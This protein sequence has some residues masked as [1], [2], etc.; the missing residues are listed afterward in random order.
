MVVTKNLRAKYIS[1][2]GEQKL[3]EHLQAYETERL[4]LMET[5]RSIKAQNSADTLAEDVGYQRTQE[6]LTYIHEQME[7]ISHCLLR[8]EIM[9][10]PKS[11]NKVQLGSTVDLSDE[12]NRLKLRVVESVEANPL[13]GKISDDSPFGKAL[14]GKSIHDEVKITK[15]KKHSSARWKILSIS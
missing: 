12:G 9:K 1:K 5:L 13:E 15:P 10:Q 3:R 11:S 4:R 14:L 2:E 6:R 8:A 7:N